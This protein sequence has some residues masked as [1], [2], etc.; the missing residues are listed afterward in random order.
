MSDMEIR[1]SGAWHRIGDFIKREISGDKDSGS[2]G[3]WSNSTLDYVT[4]GGVTGSLLGAGMGAAAHY[5]SKDKISSFK[6][7]VPVMEQKEIGQIPQNHVA[8]DKVMGDPKYVTPEGK[9]V[10]GTGVKVMGEVPKRGLLGGIQMEEKTGEATWQGHSLLAS[11]LGGALIGTFAGVLAGV[12][13]KIINAWIHPPQPEVPWQRSAPQDW[14]NSSQVNPW[15]Q[16]APDWKNSSSPEPWSQSAPGWSNSSNPPDWRNSG[17]QP[18]W[19]ESSPSPWSNTHNKAPYS[20]VH[21]NYSNMHSNYSNTH[22]NYS[23]S[24]SNYSNAHSNAWDRNISY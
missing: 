24:H 16:S 22:S 23:N 21:S 19:S 10:K 2:E 15:S 6:Y 17:S 12:A 3:T 13:L 14:N 18:S 5:V 7:E 11:V 9:P 1:K 8:A 20:D 4:R